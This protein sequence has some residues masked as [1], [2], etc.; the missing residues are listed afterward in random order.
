MR[1]LAFLCAKG[2]VG[3]TTTS[4]HAA[5]GLAA[6]GHRVLLVDADGQ[7][8]A[9]RLC[10]LLPAPGLYQLLVRDGRWADLLHL[11][12]RRTYAPADGEGV[13]AVLPSNHETML[14]PLGISDYG[15][16]RRRLAELGD[17]FD[18]AIVDTSPTPSLL[19]GSILL[20][21]DLVIYPSEM[22]YFSIKALEGSIADTR[23]FSRTREASGL[24]PVVSA[25][26][27]PTMYRAGT[28]E[29][30]EN[31]RRVQETYGDLVWPALPQ[32]ITWPEAAMQ[33]RA[34]F[35]YAPKSDAAREA[36]GLVERIEAMLV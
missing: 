21:A 2:G 18:A 35:V 23:S 27:I 34:V 4:F 9:S 8:H 14:I 13:L 3:K 22:E 24:P 1:T 10:G 17:V 16:L 31:L 20:A 29:H 33:R 36:W 11:V 30:Q 19:N 5:A 7:A 15:L 12:D 28:V 32:R 25:G 6:R 26:I